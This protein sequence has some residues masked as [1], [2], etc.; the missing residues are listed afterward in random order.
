MSTIARCSDNIEIISSSGLNVSHRGS[1]VETALI[2]VLRSYCQIPPKVRDTMNAVI[3]GRTHVHPEQLTTEISK[4]EKI[5]HPIKVDVHYRHTTWYR[6]FHL[7]MVCA[8]KELASLCVD[9]VDGI[10]FCIARRM[11][12]SRTVMIGWTISSTKNQRRHYPVTSRYFGQRGRRPCLSQLIEP[13]ISRINLP[14]QGR[15]CRIRYVQSIK[16][17][18]PPPH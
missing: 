10:T 6:P 8:P 5:S 2:S 13:S 1:F 14:L 3:T 11:C 9:N 17:P 16:M 18:A 15:G 4:I 12:M 7:S